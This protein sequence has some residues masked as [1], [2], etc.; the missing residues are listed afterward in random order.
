ML[1]SCSA[2]QSAKDIYKRYPTEI[3]TPFKQAKDRRTLQKEKLH[4]TD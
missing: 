1:I 2:G 3:N 4:F